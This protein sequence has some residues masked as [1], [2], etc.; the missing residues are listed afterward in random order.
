MDLKLLKNFQLRRRKTKKKKISFLS[1][2]AITTIFEL[3]RLPSLLISAVK[4]SFEKNNSVE[5]YWVRKESR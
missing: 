3:E 1:S 4:K 2:N 5:R